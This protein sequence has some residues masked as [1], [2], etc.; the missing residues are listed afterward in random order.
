[1][2]DTPIGLYVKGSIR[3]TEKSIAIVGSRRATLY[4]RSV[5]KK[6]SQELAQLGFCI[7]SG[8][9]RG[10]D[11]EAHEGALSVNGQTAAILGTG[12]NLIYPPEHKDLYQ[13]LIEKGAVISEFPL[14]KTA[15]RQSFPLRNRIIAGLCHVII[16][17]ESDLHGGSMITARIAGEYGRTLFAVPGRIDQPSSQGCHAL[18]REGATLLTK[19]ED[20]LEA[21]APIGQLILPFE[22]NLQNSKKA[23]TES[24]AVYLS[25]EEDYILSI[26]KESK[27][28]SI[29]DLVAIT[30][31]AAHMISSHLLSLELKKC[32]IKHMDGRFEAK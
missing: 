19:T 2:P 25:K 11:G 23:I 7:I 12:V 30:H 3:P 4:G 5:A 20:V 29:D 9:A 17:V 18:I 31:M 15:D 8:M 21:L 32:L 26:L 22:M 16:V 10:I 13:K 14:N 28:L 1:M 24:K 27:Q 6:L